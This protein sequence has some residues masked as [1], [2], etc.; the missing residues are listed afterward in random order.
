MSLLTRRWI[1]FRPSLGRFVPWVVSMSQT[2][3]VVPA[4]VTVK[5]PVLEHSE[6][7]AAS[8][9]AVCGRVEGFLELRYVRCLLQD[10]HHRRIAGESEFPAKAN[11]QR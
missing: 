8:L 1:T 3:L 10:S 11:A 4:L 2:A 6:Q 9:G 7:L 5:I